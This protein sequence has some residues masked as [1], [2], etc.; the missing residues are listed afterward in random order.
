M[1]DT[2]TEL[3]ALTGQ[4]SELEG[5]IE[6]VQEVS[7]VFRT[8]LVDMESALKSASRDAASL[9]RTLGTSLRRAFEG[10][11]FDGAK[12]SDVMRGV[13]RTLASSVFKQAFKPVETAIGGAI[14]SGL[15]SL[16]GGFAAGGA[17]ASGRVTAFAR[18]GV[19]D[20]ATPF[21]MRGGVGLMGEAGPEAI[22]PLSRGADGKLGVRAGGQ[23]GMVNVTVNVSTP[24][25]AGFQRSK[26]QVAAEIH[27]A[28]RLGKRNL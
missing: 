9:S 17:F 22:L 2:K 15:S 25:V 13:G 12:L 28:L 5:T 23:S 19:V 3:A 20:K 6:G 16:F 27:R 4:L 21:P 24:D 26:G 18:G 7:T 14:G 11:V 8:E 10:L 1:T